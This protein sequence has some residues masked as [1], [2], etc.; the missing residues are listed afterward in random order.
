MDNSAKYKVPLFSLCQ[1]ML[2]TSNCHLL[3]HGYF[4]V[5]VRAGKTAASM[6]Q[7]FLLDVDML[8]ER[9]RELIGLEWF[10][11]FMSSFW[12]WIA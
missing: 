6:D 3:I 12:F 2:K 10:R 8:P 11:Y 4:A 5:T 7:A 9:D 1:E